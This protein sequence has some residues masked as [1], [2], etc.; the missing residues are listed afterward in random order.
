VCLIG[1]LILSVVQAAGEIQTAFY[2]AIMV[3]ISWPVY[4]LIIRY[5]SN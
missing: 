4:R 3:A 5:R 1:W 2:A